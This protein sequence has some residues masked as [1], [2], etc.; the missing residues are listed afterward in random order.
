MDQDL[1]V[2]SYADDERDRHNAAASYVDLIT[3][4]SRVVG[5]NCRVQEKRNNDED[6]CQ[7]LE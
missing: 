3:G 2:R 6:D 5:R 4:G 7:F 1:V